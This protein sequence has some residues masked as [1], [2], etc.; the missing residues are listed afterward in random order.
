MLNSASKSCLR[1]LYNRRH[2]VGAASDGLGE[3]HVG[4]AALS[5]FFDRP[6]QAVEIAAE[7]R[8]GHFAHVKPLRTQGIRVDQIARLVIG[9]DPDIQTALH[10][11]AGQP[12]QGRRFFRRRESPPP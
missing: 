6:H 10:V 3:N 9:D 4:S 7:A 5:Q 1:G 12:R 2:E 11:V 8:P